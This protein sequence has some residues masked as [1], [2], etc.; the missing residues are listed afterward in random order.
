MNFLQIPPEKRIPLPAPDYDRLF[1]ELEMELLLER[2]RRGFALTSEP[3]DPHEPFTLHYLLTREQLMAEAVECLFD[4]EPLHKKLMAVLTWMK[5]SAAKAEH[6]KE[7]E[8]N[9]C[10][11]TLSASAVLS[12]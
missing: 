12:A 6:K 1:L 11:L 5:P 10:T 4:G 3:A 7:V 8:S 9:I 2:E